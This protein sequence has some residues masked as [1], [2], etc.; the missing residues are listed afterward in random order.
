MAAITVNVPRV[1][2]VF[3]SSK[4]MRALLSACDLEG[5]TCDVACPTNS[6]DAAQRIFK[7][8]GSGSLT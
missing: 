4:D 6:D 8:V 2:K 1:A 7:N 5:L 3:T